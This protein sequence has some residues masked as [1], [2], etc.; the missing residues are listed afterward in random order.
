MNDS[1]VLADAQGR[2]IC[3][4]HKA[5]TQKATLQKRLFCSQASGTNLASL[6]TVCGLT[7]Q[8]KVECTTSCAKIQEG[9]SYLRLFIILLCF[10]NSWTLSVCFL[11]LSSYSVFRLAL[12]P[13]RILSL[14]LRQALFVPRQSLA[15]ILLEIF[16]ISCI[17]FL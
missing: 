11:L 5:G 1:V 6:D 8:D 2:H 3:R 15:N 12:V 7:N 16:E 9:E 17:S 4:A 10:I 13:D 14:V